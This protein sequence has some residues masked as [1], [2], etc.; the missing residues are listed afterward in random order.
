M[1]QGSLLIRTQMRH[2]TLVMLA[3]ASGALRRR[4]LL[5]TVEVRPSCRRLFLLRRAGES[6][7][8]LT[9]TA[10]VGGEPFKVPHRPESRTEAIFYWLWA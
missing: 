2:I 3:S 4:E 7:N 5:L 9:P 8:R 10:S 1:E 6:L